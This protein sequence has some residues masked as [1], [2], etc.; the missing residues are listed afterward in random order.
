M[1]SFKEHLY[2]ANIKQVK[3]VI[4]DYIDLPLEC[5]GFAQVMTYLLTK[6]KIKHDVYGGKVQW[7]DQIFNPHFWIKLDGY[8]IDCALRIWFGPSAPHG[9]IELK[10]YPELKYDGKKVKFNVNDFVFKIL[11]MQG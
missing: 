10:K 1:I 8:V 5:D 7:K 11:T 6:H 9:I 4:S 2:E 3:K